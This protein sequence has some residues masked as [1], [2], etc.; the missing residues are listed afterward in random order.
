MPRPCAVQSLLLVGSSQTAGATA[1]NSLVHRVGQGL[2]ESGCVTFMQSPC[3]QG[4]RAYVL[5]I[6]VACWDVRLGSRGVRGTSGATAPAF[7]TGTP[8]KG[9]MPLYSDVI[10]SRLQDPWLRNVLVHLLQK[11]NALTK[12]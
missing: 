11:S 9:Q 2:G 12:V 8:V 6:H 3:R 7:P 4:R 5:R 1:S 10:G